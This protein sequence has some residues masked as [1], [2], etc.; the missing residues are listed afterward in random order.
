MWHNGDESGEKVQLMTIF[1]GQL[2]IILAMKRHKTLKM[3]LSFLI[4]PRLGLF[5]I[6]NPSGTNTTRKAWVCPYNGH[7]GGLT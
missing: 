7:T 2:K 4:A 1:M 3:I 6:E 5:K